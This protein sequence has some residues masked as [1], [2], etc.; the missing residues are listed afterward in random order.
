MEMTK[1]NYLKTLK[2]VLK[3]LHLK[4]ISRLIR[5]VIEKKPLIKGFDFVGT[6]KSI[7]TCIEEKVQRMN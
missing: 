5:A 6:N 7:T 4:E 2:S 3:Y 1:K